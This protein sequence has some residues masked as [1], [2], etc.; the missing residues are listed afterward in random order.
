M[1][2]SS[3]RGEKRDKYSLFKS[4]WRHFSQ[5]GLNK[6]PVSVICIS[7]IRRSNQ[8]SE[9]WTLIFGGQGP[10]WSPWLQQYMSTAAYHMA[11]GWVIHS[12]YYF[13]CWHW[14]KLTIILL[15]KFPSGRHKH[16][17]NHQSSKI[18]YFR[19][20]LQVQLL[21]GGEMDSWHFLIHYLQFA[22]YVQW[23]TQAMEPDCWCSNFCKA[24]CLTSYVTL[25]KVPVWLSFLICKIGI[26]TL[27]ILLK[28]EIVLRNNWNNLCKFFK[29]VPGS[30][31]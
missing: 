6:Q 9:H 25:G 18:N 28:H 7:M 12:Y 24:P 11:M 8:Q 2:G 30:Q 31:F 1:S 22:V 26:E 23:H 3:K 19:Q 27:S 17:N 29:T 13:K 16:S 10:Y 20:L 15:A 5:L 4:S 21:S 14:S